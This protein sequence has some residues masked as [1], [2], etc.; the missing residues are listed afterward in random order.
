[1]T[2]TLLSAVALLAVCHGAAWA[3]G[4]FE[5]V[6]VYMEQTVE[7][8]DSEIEFDAISGGDGLTT[9]TVAAPDGRIV[10][11]YK[12]ADSKLG[13]R[14]L[15]LESP[16]P[17]N[18]GSLKADFPA[19]IYRFTG[20]LTTGVTLQSEATLS[21]KLPDIAHVVW[22]RPDEKNVPVTGMQVKWNNVKDAAGLLVVIEQEKTGRE[23]KA[24]LPATATAFTVSDGFLAPGL[25]YKLAV[26][27]VAKDGNRS[28]T[29]TTF[30]TAAR[31]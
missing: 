18:D 10:I 23:I 15:T 4:K 11:D 7:D 22:P 16:E 14:H 3:A 29:E 24:N 28:V 9:L 26:G 30:V 8:G 12:A 5:S 6:S 21:H 27:T 17:K 2:K 25:E 20:V 13:L 19:G 1:M 31:K